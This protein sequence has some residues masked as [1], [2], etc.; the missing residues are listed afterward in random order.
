MDT[1]TK[2]HWYSSTSLILL[3]ILFLA[4]TMLIGAFLTGLRLDLTQ[5][6]LYT[7]S[8][9]TIN[10]LEEIE[11]PITLE[12]FFS[13]EASSELPMVR[14]YARRVQELLDEMAQH[15][16]GELI[17]RR[18]DP[19]PFSE[20]EDRAV[21]FGLEGV[22]IG[23]GQ[24]SLYLGLVGTNRVDGREVLPFLSPARES[25]LEYELARMI[26]ILSQPQ[27]PRVG[28]LTGLPMSG[29]MDFRTG[30][31]RE[32][33]AVYQEVSEL[34]ELEEIDASATSLPEDIELLV[35]VHP[36]E[37]DQAL[38]ADIE[39]FLFNGGRLLAFLDPFSES[40]PGPDPSD[41]M[42]AVTA[43]RHSSLGPL[44][45]AWGLAFPTDRFVADLGL[46]LQVNLQ[47]G[48]PPVRHPAI[49]GIPAQ[50]MRSD[51][52][53][54][55]DLE[56]LNLASTGWFELLED[57]PLMLQPLIVSSPNSGP[58]S[59]ERL[60]VL[61]DPSVLIDEVGPTGDGYVLAAR[62]SGDV[63][64]VLTESS[65]SDTAVNSINAIVVGDTDFLADRYW[66]QRQRF[67]GT[68]LLEP[69]A[70]N[71]DF[72]INA[73]DNLLGN[74]DLIS[75]RGRATSNRP[76][77]LVDE[78]RRSAEQSLRATE[79]RLEAELAEAEARLN[80]LQ[81]ARGDTDLSVLTS[82]QEEEIDRFIARRLEIRQQLRGVRRDLDRDI[83]A[84][85]A[86][87]K[88]INIALMPLLVTVFALSLAWRRRQAFRR[89][90]SGETA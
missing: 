82:E 48:Q 34:F 13:E 75:V 53:I 27:R 56:V 37:L 66:V 9:G 14:N 85:G 8:P 77:T 54:T 67:F 88:V 21:L 12:F 42:G 7:L 45:D 86:R 32:P 6:K 47:Q 90:R 87:V 23:V 70:N 80:E 3:A 28:W 76:F 55:G 51:D 20:A 10:L 31:P 71:A 79:Q 4:L 49:L 50:N 83:E 73:I 46:A 62:I 5:N 16:G 41:P 18:I 68:T 52:V 24:E 25:F 39:R 64:P 84:L 36:K 29:G 58:L 74:A 11:E 44:L 2:K 57:S 72:V 26:Y 38:L 78:L 43:D 19:E 63:E 1:A 22:P 59:T 15:A 69:F 81:Q 17:V 30:S 60:R 65:S 89:S 35:L 40:D 61:E 33:W